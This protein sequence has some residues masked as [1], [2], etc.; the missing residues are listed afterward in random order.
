MDKQQLQQIISVA[1]NAAQG[2]Q[3]SLSM[4]QEFAKMYAQQDSMAV[5]VKQTIDSMA[6]QGDQNAI[7]ASQVIDT[8][9]EQ[10]VRAAKFGAKL[11]YINKL[12]NKCPE[13]YEMQIFQQGG[14]VCKKCMKKAQQGTTLPKKP[15]S[16]KEQF[17]VEMDKCGGKAK[18]PKKEIGGQIPEA[19]CGKKMP[20][21]AN[22]GIFS[23]P[24]FN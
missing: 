9:A 13:G 11:N 1:C 4:M 20:F 19:K 22:G 15:M 16:I 18:K 21:K 12:N 17:E 5:Q 6:E 2:D 10:M 7:M 3:Q 14:R 24:K 8:L 23:F